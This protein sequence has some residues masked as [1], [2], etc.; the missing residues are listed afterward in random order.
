[1]SL[2]PNLLPS[3]INL[4]ES[5]AKSQKHIDARRNLYEVFTT[6]SHGADPSLIL[7]VP[8][9]LEVPYDPAPEKRN[10]IWFDVLTEVLKLCA[11]NCQVRS[12]VQQ[13]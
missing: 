5:T 4:V 12:K 11:C 2:N 13:A 7:N 1:M 10:W 6:F 3:N 8:D 9:S